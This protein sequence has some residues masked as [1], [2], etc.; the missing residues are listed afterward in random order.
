LVVSR[1]V[2]YGIVT[3]GR[4]GL[5]LAGVLACGDAVLSH[6]SAAALHGLPVSDND[7]THV[8]APSK[9]HRRRVDCH[10]VRLAPADLPEKRSSKGLR[11]DDRHGA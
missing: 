11:G 6:R 8:S 10:Q 4:R 1:F 9:H 7:L 5:G 3:A 2:S